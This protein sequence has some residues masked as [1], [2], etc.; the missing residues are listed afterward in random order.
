M[1]SDIFLDRTLAA[2]VI[3]HTLSDNALLASRDT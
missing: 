1:G 2:H 3:R